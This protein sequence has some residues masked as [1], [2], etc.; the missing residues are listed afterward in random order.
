MPKAPITPRTIGGT[1]SA[2]APVPY[3]MSEY[4]R[5]AILTRD[6]YPVFEQTCRTALIVARAWSIVHGDEARPQPQNL[7]QLQDYDDRLL[8]GIQLISSSVT[9]TFYNRINLF[10]NNQDPQG[11]WNELAKEKRV[12]DIVDQDSLRNRFTKET[13]NPKSESLRSYVTKLETY[14]TQLAGT[15]YQI[16]DQQLLNR[17]LQSLPADSIWQ[18]AKFFALQEGR[19]LA[20]TVMLLQSYENFLLPSSAEATTSIARETSTRGRDRGRGRRRRGHKGDNRERSKSKGK[21]DKLGKDQCKF[22]RKKGH[23]EAD[24]IQYKKAQNKLLR[25]EERGKKTVIREEEH[26]KIAPH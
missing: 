26:V 6:N 18:Q 19:D 2:S 10:I 25:K 5:I 8:R 15:T 9:E 4:G 24:C 7:A 20:S 13:W 11:M 12:L 17:I 1:P 14:R 16:S 21:V 22:C 23:Y 3:Y